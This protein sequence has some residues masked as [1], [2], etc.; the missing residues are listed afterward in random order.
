M[1]VKRDRHVCLLSDKV[2]SV[3]DDP[4]PREVD[5]RLSHPEEEAFILK[6]NA[7]FELAR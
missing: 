6:G 1:K 5:S 3:L 7:V 2:V 4:A